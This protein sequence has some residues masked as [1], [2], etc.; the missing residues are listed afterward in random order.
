MWYP[1]NSRV[2]ELNELI[3]SFRDKALSLSTSGDNLLLLASSNV[4]KLTQKSEL[5]NYLPRDWL[6]IGSQYRINTKIEETVKSVAGGAILLLADWLSQNNYPEE[7]LKKDINW[8]T[9]TTIFELCSILGNNS[10]RRF[11][12]GDEE[13]KADDLWQSLMPED[14]FDIDKIEKDIQPYLE[15]LSNI[16]SDSYL[17]V[18]S[19]KINVLDRKSVV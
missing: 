3:I 8:L 12:S 6:W 2:E 16:E 17:P 18:I 19:E 10:L 1:T 5:S 15:R 13:I 4:A 14:S 11:L 7:S 9:S